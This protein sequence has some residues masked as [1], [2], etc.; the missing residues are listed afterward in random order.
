MILNKEKVGNVRH[1]RDADSTDFRDIVDFLSVCQGHQLANEDDTVSKARARKLRI[2]N[3][4]TQRTRECD[5]TELGRREHLVPKDHPLVRDQGIRSTWGRIIPISQCISLPMYAVKLNGYLRSDAMVR[6]KPDRHRSTWHTLLIR[7]LL[8]P[9]YSIPQSPN[10]IAAPGNNEVDLSAPISD[11]L[12]GEGYGNLNHISV[13]LVRADQK[14]L[15]TDDI[16]RLS[17][18]IRDILWPRL[19]ERSPD[20]WNTRGNHPMY[21]TEETYAELEITKEDYHE[22]WHQREDEKFAELAGRKD[23]QK[24]KTRPCPYRLK[25]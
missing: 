7:S 16:G 4:Y 22:F 8:D 11:E 21:W 3:V 10:S 24:V 9:R 15:R 5:F 12:W 23:S 18:W 2:L 13:V 14:D 17:R 20:T 25:K 6:H 1:F 19:M